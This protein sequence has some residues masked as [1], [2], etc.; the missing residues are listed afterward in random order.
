M[1]HASENGIVPG[2]VTDQGRITLPAGSGVNGTVTASGDTVNTD[3]AAGEP[4]SG[5]NV[6]LYN[7]SSTDPADEVA[8]TT[9]SQNGAYA[10]I[11]PS[12][13]NYT[14]E[15]SDEEFVTE[16]SLL[17]IG[18]NETVTEAFVLDYAEA[19]AVSGEIGLDVVDP[20][21]DV[22]VTVTVVGTGNSTTVL[23]AGSE[24]ATQYTIP[25]VDVN[26]G[27]GYTVTATAETPNYDDPA[28]VKNVTVDVG[29]TTTDVDFGFTRRTGNLDGTV[30]N[31]IG[32][33]IQGATVEVFGFGSSGPLVANDTTD[34]S[35]AYSIPDLPVGDHLVTVSVDGAVAGE[36]EAT[37]L[38]NQ[39]TSANFTLETANFT[40][41][42][43]GTLVGAAG[44]T[45]TTNVTIENT[46]DLPGEQTIELDWGN[47]TYTNSTSVTLD[48]GTETVTPLS[49]TTDPN[50]GLG[51]YNVTVT[52]DNEI[53]ESK[54]L[55]SPTRSL[56]QTAVSPG[57]T[58]NVTVSGQLSEE[59]T[60]VFQDG[61]SPVANDS[62]IISTSVDFLFP[63]ATDR[64]IGLA[65]GNPV[66]PGPLEI[67]YEIYLPDDVEQG[68]VYEWEP[69]ESSNG[70][71]LEVGAGDDKLPVLGDQS[72]QI[73][74]LTD[75]TGPDPVS[76]PLDE[77]TQTLAAENAGSLV[78]DSMVRVAPE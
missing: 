47:G 3:Q 73:T 34:A 24:N 52:S 54:S 53:D 59:D 4:V 6:T 70:S 2:G 18:V 33:A 72:F 35:G 69:K 56:N 22:N 8:T 32:S 66:D 25:D 58:V 40:V 48:G 39:T 13:G 44:E 15:L 11:L 16:S 60:V 37:I 1:P 31:G 64:N 61:W 26:V 51:S 5:A 43:D 23:L 77:S 38:S 75:S 50:Q 68:T 49:I 41:A 55:V 19:G 21:E 46:G 30:T 65:S 28:E 20:D 12:T 78:S 29:A 7:G 45:Q 71:A 27:D 76:T 17:T 62:A 57:G 14:V 74:N 42:T 67:V 63:E 9:T 10:F 36:T